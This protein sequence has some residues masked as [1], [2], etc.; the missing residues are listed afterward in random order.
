MGTPK[1]REEEN[2]KNMKC[3]WKLVNNLGQLT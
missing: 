1:R 3:A 2:G